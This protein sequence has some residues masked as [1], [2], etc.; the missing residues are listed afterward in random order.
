MVL[1]GVSRG[2]AGVAVAVFAAC[3][4]SDPDAPSDASV[5]FDASDASDAS[6]DAV[7]ATAEA[8]SADACAD[9]SSSPARSFSL[10]AWPKLTAATG[11]DLTASAHVTTTTVSGSPAGVLVSP[12]GQWVF[13]AVS[14]ANPQ[15]QLAVLRRSGAALTVDHGFMVPSNETP[16]GLAR[17]SDGKTLAMTTSTQV[18]LFDVA[19]AEANAAGAM[20][21]SVADQSSGVTIDVA[22]SHDDGF[23]FAALE[24]DR[25][26]AVID[27][28]KQAYVG[29]I[30]IAGDAVTSVAVS[31]DGSR[32]YVVCEVADEFKKANPNPA[33]DQVVGSVTVVDAAKAQ[34]APAGSVLGH[35]FVGRAPVRAVVSPD[36]ATLWVTAR[37]SNALVALDAASLLPGG[38]GDP[39][40]STTAVGPAPVGVALVAGGAGIAVA[41]S[42][43]ILQ[44]NTN[45]TVTLLD[46]HLARSASPGAIVGQ[47]GVGAFPREIDDDATALFVS[48]FDSGSVSGI[49]LTKLPMP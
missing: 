8:S 42:N 9:A 30:P 32:L 7:D 5:P 39:L 19:K 47:V 34:T 29:S 14:N 24:Y 11:T 3:H 41:D 49:D 36:G 21:A 18:M 1:R 38:C 2:L 25:A 28:K 37:G 27:V 40:L 26:V 6:D 12:D 31:P 45:Q 17:S 20:I 48:N 15:G 10:S 35:A 22:F 23:V 43:R 44:P 4:S 46:A 16:F 33:V 13:A